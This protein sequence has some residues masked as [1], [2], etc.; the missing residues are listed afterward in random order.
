MNRRDVLKMLVGGGLSLVLGTAPKTVNAQQIRDRGDLRVLVLSDINGPYGT[1]GY[2]RGVRQSVGY[3]VASWR[4]DI[5]LSPGDLVAG[6]NR[7]LP[8]ERFAQMW[9]GF[10]REVGSSLRSANIPFAPAMGNHDASSLT[11]AD[12]N[13]LFA[14]ERDAARAFWNDSRYTP[15]LWFVD[16]DDFP[17]R[18]TFAFSGQCGEV[19]VLVWDASSATLT[20][21]TLAWA[22]ATLSSER[23]RQAS[24]RVV[25]GHLPLFGIA[26]GRNNPGN[27]IT[28]GD[29]VRRRLEALDVHTY[30]SGHHHAYYPARRGN[31]NLLHAGGVG[32]RRLLGSSQPART[33]V[34]V[35]D[36]FFWPTV[37]VR[38]TTFETAGFEEVGGSSLPPHLDGLNGRVTRHNPV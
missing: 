14:R 1:V 24:V 8:D 9:A 26:E 36:I 25:L 35:M 13:Y 5:V 29:A 34:T 38:Y 4:P 21:E 19:F 33:T 30:I 2:G 3:A 15:N 31:L 22:E 37:R 12:G 32:P 17:F 28:G 6:Q 11:D 18:Y 20:P 16:R 7:N 23:A 27:V 10:E